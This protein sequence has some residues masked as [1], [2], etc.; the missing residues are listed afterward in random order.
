MVL[1]NEAD[2]SLSSMSRES[3]DCNDSISSSK[4]KSL[5][6]SKRPSSVKSRGKTNKVDK[7]K[8]SS[9]LTDLTN[10]KPQDDVK[11]IMKSEL[12]IEDQKMLA[13]VSDAINKLNEGDKTNSLSYIKLISEFILGDHRNLHNK[14][15][16]F[17]SLDEFVKSLD[18]YNLSISS[19][20]LFQI[21]NCY[22]CSME[23]MMKLCIEDSDL[24]NNLSCTI[25][26]QF[27]N[28]FDI[29]NSMYKL[30]N[31]EYKSTKKL[32]KYLSSL[33]HLLESGCKNYNY[34]LQKEHSIY[35]DYALVIN[36][37]YSVL[38][39]IGK[40]NSKNI[41]DLYDGL[42]LIC[43]SIV[44]I[45]NKG[46]SDGLNKS[47]K[48]AIRKLFTNIAYDIMKIVDNIAGIRFKLLNDLLR[49]VILTIDTAD[50]K[51]IDVSNRLIN[52]KI[53][54]MIYQSNKHDLLSKDYDKKVY[55]ALYKYVCLATYFIYGLNANYFIYGLN[56]DRSNIEFNNSLIKFIENLKK[57]YPNP[58][59]DNRYFKRYVDNISYEQI[60]NC[61]HNSNIK[62]QL[63]RKLECI[64]ERLQSGNISQDQLK[65]ELSNL[66]LDNEIDAIRGNSIYINRDAVC[67]YISSK[68]SEIESLVKN[69]KQSPSVNKLEENESQYTQ[70]ENKPMHIQ[71]TSEIE[72]EDI[73]NYSKELVE[74]VLENV[75]EKLKEELLKEDEDS[76]DELEKDLSSN[77][78]DKQKESFNDSLDK[79][80]KGLESSGTKDLRPLASNEIDNDIEPAKCSGRYIV[81]VVDEKQKTCNHLNETIKNIGGRICN[82][83]ENIS[84]RINLFM[85]IDRFVK[86]KHPINNIYVFDFNY[87]DLNNLLQSYELSAQSILSSKLEESMRK[88]IKQLIR[89]NFVNIFDIYAKLMIRERRSY[90]FVSNHVSSL[91]DTLCNYKFDDELIDTANKFKTIVDSLN[92]FSNKAYEYTNEDIIL[93]F[94]DIFNMFSDSLIDDIKCFSDDTQSLIKESFGNLI[95]KLIG[96]INSNQVSID[97]NIYVGK[98]S[99]YID[100][101]T[102]QSLYDSF[103]NLCD[104]MHDFMN[105]YFKFSQNSETKESGVRCCVKNTLDAFNAVC[106]DICE[107][108]K[109]YPSS[110]DLQ[111]LCLDIYCNMSF[112]NVLSNRLYEYN[113]NANN[114]LN[115]FIDNNKDILDKKDVEHVRK[116]L[117]SYKVINDL[118]SNLSYIY[119]N[120]I[121]DDGELLDKLIL[122]VNLLRNL[123]ESIVS[124]SYIQE[125]ENRVSEHP[126][127]K[128]LNDSMLKLDQLIKSDQLN[129]AGRYNLLDEYFSFMK[130]RK[131]II[132]LNRNPTPFYNSKLIEYNNYIISNIAYIK[133]Y[134][135]ADGFIK[136]LQ[137]IE[138]IDCKDS[139]D[140]KIYLQKLNDKEKKFIEDFDIQIMNMAKSLESERIQQSSVEVE[141]LSTI[142]EEDEPT[143]IQQTSETKEYINNKNNLALETLSKKLEN[144]LKELKE[145]QQSSESHIK[146]NNVPLEPIH[147]K[148]KDKTEI[149][150]AEGVGEVMYRS[151]ESY[152][153]EEMSGEHNES[154]D[155]PCDDQIE[156]I[157]DE[158]C[159]DQ[160]EEITTHGASQTQ[161]SDLNKGMTKYALADRVDDN[162]KK[163]AR[164]IA[165][166]VEDK[167]SKI[168]I[169]DSRICNESESNY[170]TANELEDEHDNSSKP[171]EHRSIPKQTHHVH[172]KPSVVHSNK[173]PIPTNTMRNI[174]NTSIGK[175][176]PRRKHTANKGKHRL[177]KPNTRDSS[178][179]RDKLKSTISKTSTDNTASSSKHTS[180]TQPSSSNAK[181]TNQNT[182]QN[183]TNSNSTTST[184][185]KK[186]GFFGIIKSFFV[187][188]KDKFVSGVKYVCNGIKSG[189]KYVWNG[190]RSLFSSVWNS[191]TRLFR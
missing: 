102:L 9:S 61:C 69:S 27:V 18:T 191:I 28:I 99:K 122:V 151:S 83:D 3:V 66:E 145:K 38:G 142:I 129:A 48:S 98:Y 180:V 25:K 128:D 95:H 121:K 100:C 131:R 150:K 182:T 97:R 96:L 111:D 169:T 184:T 165:D 159:D 162:S 144:R 86:G 188:C 72:E 176:Q 108:R 92:S 43:L 62:Q 112:V 74:D 80:E 6:K 82:K 89:S 88:Y 148:T 5:S 174:A 46:I 1:N 140:A 78:T 84:D 173:K 75:K 94:F 58:D 189:A 91:I 45:D 34:S 73:H 132:D 81:D 36:K 41:C 64:V 71:Q 156:E 65:V 172:T 77:T 103:F 49:H 55:P 149:E 20:D 118:E 178:N 179:N 105:F 141:N 116:L 33:G 31:K 10:H 143:H 22:Q 130:S 167:V 16:S 60:I 59:N 87:I 113:D 32:S 136:K 35:N 137:D 158:P 39:L 133:S 2:I 177:I 146:D 44:D 127:L 19:D 187:A 15:K 163:N 153:V 124:E 50:N 12:V 119:N 183:T 101:D 21:L 68:L 79:L 76:L 166:N 134:Y 135:K 14:L 52:D 7:L 40:V 185:T 139:I 170:S 54:S 70:Q 4:T 164:K 47:T 154:L 90:E 125:T 42:Y 63:E 13:N 53:K 186:K 57:H 67:K 106:S 168:V 85:D 24:H 11:N 23:K 114:N 93:D 155:E 8:R 138:P 104:K 29:Y 161:P 17:E 160:I 147:I 171:E 30:L 51:N 152:V 120:N 123:D 117:F 175:L 190:I 110:E 26:N 181:Q 126:I 56:E 107:S 115:Y 157:L 37:Y 109:L